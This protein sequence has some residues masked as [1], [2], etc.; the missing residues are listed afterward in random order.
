MPHTFTSLRNSVEKLLEAEHFLVR[1]NRVCGLE[2]QFELN[3]FLSSSRSVTFLLRKVMAGVSGFGDWYAKEQEK[4]KKDAA[5][6]FFL[7]LRNFSQKQGPV[8]VVG[9]SVWGGGWT[10]RFVGRD[11]EVPDELVG[12]DVGVCCSMHLAKLA[13]LLLKASNAFPFQSCPAR[14]FTEEGMRSLSFSW[15]DVEAAVGLPA[16]WTDVAGIPESEKFRILRGEIEP[17]DTATIERIASGI[18]LLAGKPVEFPPSASLDLVDDLAM[19][20]SGRDRPS[21]PRDVF[22][23]AMSKRVGGTEKDDVK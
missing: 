8:A 20:L 4:M 5:M 10:Y 11:R 23:A 22:L 3:A 21:S 17:L 1:L 2:F 15:R 7:E 19:L 9:G 6:R 16:H 12:R 18:I 14:A 13:A